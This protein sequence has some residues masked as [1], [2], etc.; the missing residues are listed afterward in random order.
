MRAA[1]TTLLVAVG[2]AAAAAQAV[3]LALAVDCSAAVSPGALDHFWRSCGFEPANL[4]YRL[5]MVENLVQIG[6][7]PLRGIRQVRIHYILDLLTITSINDSAIGAAD[8]AGSGNTGGAGSPLGYDWTSLD[9]L[10]DLLVA[11]RLS[12]GFEVMGSPSGFPPLPQSFWA[13]DGPY[14]ANATLVLWRALVRDVL[15]R[16]SDRYGTAEVTTWRIEGWNEVSTPG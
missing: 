1:S 10:F 13:D 15:L 2:A 7:T 6:A 14:T 12:P 5:D 8:I 9:G 4:T 3:P 11:N 16:Y